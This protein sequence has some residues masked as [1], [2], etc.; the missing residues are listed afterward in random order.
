MRTIALM[1]AA[2]F[3]A[4]AAEAEVGTYYAERGYWAVFNSPSAC[5]AVNRPPADLN[6]SPYN[7][8]Q[9]T[10][11]PASA[12]SVNVFFW[13]GAVMMDRD[14]KL[15]LAFNNGDLTLPAKATIGDFVLASEPDM[16]LWRKF[17][18]ASNLS[19]RV[20]G[21]PGLAL[22]FTLDDIGWVLDGLTACSRLLPKE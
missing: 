20:V 10:V 21:E 9:I 17:Q 1:I 12:I 22:T 15:Q 8:L 18:D 16:G 2:V 6:A 7:A 11:R 19:V 14:Y 5:Q 13:P 4:S 3:V